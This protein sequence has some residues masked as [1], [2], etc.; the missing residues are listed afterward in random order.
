MTMQN[1]Q[2][3]I[4]ENKQRLEVRSLKGNNYYCRNIYL[5]IYALDFHKVSVQSPASPS[6]LAFENLDF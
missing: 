1:F 3:A 2:N 6:W 5:Y 4:L